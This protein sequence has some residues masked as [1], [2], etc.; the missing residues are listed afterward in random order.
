MKKKKQNIILKKTSKYILEDQIKNK[1]YENEVNVN[2]YLDH[3]IINFMK[4][5]IY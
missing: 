5:K 1:Y 4:K 3:K 2:H